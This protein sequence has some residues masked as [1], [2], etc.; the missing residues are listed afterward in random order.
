MKDVALRPHPRQ[1]GRIVA[2]EFAMKQEGGAL[3]GIRVLDLSRILA[4]PYCTMMLADLGA[5]VIKVERPDGGDDTR[6]W[7]PPFEQGES[8]FFLS[9]N[10][11][12]RSIC[13]DLKTEAGK[14]V[15]QRLLP[16]TDVVIQNFRPG[17]AERLGFGPDRLCER[18]PRLVYC[19]LS[20][21]GDD[22]PFSDR[23]GYDALLQAMGG[24]MSITG[25]A[26]GPPTKVGVG[27][28]DVMTGTLGANAILAALFERER[29]GKGQQVATSLLEAVVA[30]L[31]NQGQST[32]MTGRAPGRLG[33]A[34]PN[35]VPYQ[36]YRAA[37]DWIFLAV[38][39]DGLFEKC[40]RVLGCS[41]LVDDPRFSTNGE[42][43][44]HRAELNGILDDVFMTRSAD[45][46][47]RDLLE[48]GV[49]VGPIHDIAQVLRH[50]QVEHL[51]LVQ[52]VHH[53]TLGEVELV[54]SPLRLSRTPSRIQS[55]PPSL[56]E[57]EEDILSELGL[58][59][60]FLRA[61]PARSE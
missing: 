16:S 13:L 35:I 4:G 38:G 3:S 6:K 44:V 12:K 17:V 37:D 1:H 5:D 2:I 19:S 15:I 57:H 31:V 30:S 11:N 29:S 41:A 18:Y 20:S 24:L 46:W 28:V 53:S 59:S 26:D 52:S 54:A 39:N 25:D 45:R 8:A 9:V 49:P 48:M 40:C 21:F 58:P 36:P 22:G 51:G 23:A 50:P 7:G 33:S 10:R 47:I 34:H 61:S 32:L 27:I 60:N 56:G 43:V 42:R 14:E 55:A